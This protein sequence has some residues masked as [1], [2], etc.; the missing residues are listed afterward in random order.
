MYAIRPE[1]ETVWSILM[2]K[3]SIGRQNFWLFFFQYVISTDE[4]F[5]CIIIYITDIY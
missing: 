5:I 4:M 3:L 1:N 2:Q